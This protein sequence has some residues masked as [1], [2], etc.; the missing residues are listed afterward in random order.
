MTD[1]K[2]IEW[3]KLPVTFDAPGFK[4]A[5]DEF[6]FTFATPKKYQDPYINAMMAR[7]GNYG[8][9]FFVPCTQE[10]AEVLLREKDAP[11]AIALGSAPQ[12]VLESSIV[13]VE[14]M[15]EVLGVDPRTVQLDAEKGVLV[16]TGRG[17]YDT[18]ASCATLR[19]AWKEA[20][21]GQT[22]AYNDEKVKELRVKRQDREAKL[23]ERLGC[24]VNAQRVRQTYE[25]I[26][27]A[28]RN[29]V[30]NM[31]KKLGPEMDM[32]SGTE[33]E[34]KLNDW[35][36]RHLKEFSSWEAILAV[37][38]NAAPQPSGNPEKKNKGKRKKK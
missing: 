4:K 8:V 9:L 13:P 26:E 33:A 31:P 2:N 34:V 22:D 29:A 21:N 32:V 12:E 17:Q 18:L 15:A 28:E 11:G 20:E 3:V 14:V 36:R 16:R 24:L 25:A 23:A 7:I 30:L 5:S 6:T 19:K 10:Q 37:V 38:R 35:A 1:K 27:A